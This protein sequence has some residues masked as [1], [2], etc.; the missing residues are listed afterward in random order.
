MVALPMDGSVVARG[1]LPSRRTVHGRGGHAG[2]KARLGLGALTSDAVADGLRGLV[3]VRFGRGA[4]EA[5]AQ[6]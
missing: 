1:P 5:E 4:A 6:R 3:D 2:T